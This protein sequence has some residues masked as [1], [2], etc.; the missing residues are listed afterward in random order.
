MYRMSSESAYIVEL[1]G[2]GLNLKRELSQTNATELLVW[3]VKGGRFQPHAA[4]HAQVE[5]S[6]AVPTQSSTVAS[7]KPSGAG[8]VDHQELTSVREFLDDHSPSRVPDKIA[9]FALY[10]RDHRN[11]K[12]FGRPDVS[13]LFQEAA[14]P[15]PK[16]LGRD[17]KWTQT[18]AWIAPIPGNREV[19]YLTKKG[20][21]AVKGRFSKEVVAKTR[22]SAPSPRK[23]SSTDTVEATASIPANLDPATA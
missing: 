18:I 14:E 1:T 22:L 20:E 23:R 2:P 13:A 8:A 11:Q 3:L 17:L 5:A 9:C 21:E 15:L 12:E 4:T 19:Y 7:A 10:L 6:G 16:N